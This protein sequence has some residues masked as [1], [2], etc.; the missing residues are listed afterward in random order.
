MKKLIELFQQQILTRTSW[1]L[2]VVLLWYR[3]ALCV[4]LLGSV[5][6]NVALAVSTEK[7]EEDKYQ[8]QGHRLSTNQSQPLIIKRQVLMVTVMSTVQVVRKGM[9]TRDEMPTLPV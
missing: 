9:K 2:C 4:L 7:N 5:S 6:Q 3:N 1:M 8:L